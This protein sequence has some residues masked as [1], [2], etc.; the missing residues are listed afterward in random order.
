MKRLVALA[1]LVII[2]TGL[3]LFGLGNLSL[4]LLIAASL[5]LEWL[6][7]QRRLMIPILQVLPLR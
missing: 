5:M 7:V 2:L 6:A 3:L 4:L 1:I